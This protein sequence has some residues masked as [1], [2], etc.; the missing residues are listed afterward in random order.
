MH[1][2]VGGRTGWMDRWS[3]QEREREREAA[4]VGMSQWSRAR[5]ALLRRMR[6]GLGWRTMLGWAGVVWV[7]IGRCNVAH[8]QGCTIQ[9]LPAGL[10]GFCIVTRWPP[11][12][13]CVCART[14]RCGFPLPSLFLF[15][16]FFPVL[17]DGFSLPSLLPLSTA[18]LPHH[19]NAHCQCLP[20]CVGAVG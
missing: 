1:A 20:L 15:F 17:A 3:E 16:F 7:V 6:R 19:T 9:Y 13:A 11:V 10:H 8:S 18:L 5:D 12:Y 14:L 2:C 4:G